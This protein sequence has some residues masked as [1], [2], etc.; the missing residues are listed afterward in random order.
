M[1]SCPVHINDGDIC[2]R[3]RTSTEQKV[4]RTSVVGDRHAS[5]NLVK[6]PM[7]PTTA[8][9]IKTTIILTFLQE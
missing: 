9:R 5:K 3:D 8:E 1:M 2:Q 4:R 6:Y 7:D